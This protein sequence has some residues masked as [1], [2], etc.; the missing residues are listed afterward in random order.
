MLGVVGET[1]SAVIIASIVLRSVALDS[2]EFPFRGGKEKQPPGPRRDTPPAF[3]GAGH[4]AEV[5]VRDVVPGDLLQLAAGDLVPADATVLAADIPGMGQAARIV[6]YSQ[7]RPRQ[8]GAHGTRDRDWSPHRIRR[9]RPRT[10]GHIVAH[11]NG[12]EV[13][14]EC[15]GQ[16]YWAWAGPPY[17][18]GKVV[19]ACS[20]T[21]RPSR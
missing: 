20:A 12:G 6:R 10:C 1:V 13:R 9:N 2:P 11:Q 18:R 7:A 15:A 8:R 16:R 19:V 21:D 17:C 14:F 5:A 4:C 3:A